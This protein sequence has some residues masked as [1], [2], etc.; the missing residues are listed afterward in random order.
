M[1]TKFV[2]CFGEIRKV[3]VVRET[4]KCVFILNRNGDERKELKSTEFHNYFDSFD[5]AKNFLIQKQSREID[6]I[7]RRLEAEKDKL[8]QIQGLKIEDIRERG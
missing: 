8:G 2:V 5:A 3:S 4:D 1:I 6:A 7:K